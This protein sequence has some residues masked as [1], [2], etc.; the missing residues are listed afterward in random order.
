MGKANDGVGGIDTD[1]DDIGR[2]LIEEVVHEM[3][4]FVRGDKCEKIYR[5]E[6]RRRAW[7][8]A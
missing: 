6:S 8:N 1:A 3:I 4:I 2:R 7:E 5:E